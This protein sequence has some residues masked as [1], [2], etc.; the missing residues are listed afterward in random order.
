MFM[1]HPDNPDTALPVSERAF[2]GVWESKG[3]LR[4]EVDAV[5]HVEQVHEQANQ[6]PADDT[7]RKDDET[8]ELDV[9]DHPDDAPASDPIQF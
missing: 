8:G 1:V 2:A 4:C 5:G 3:F 9:T 7:A 6:V